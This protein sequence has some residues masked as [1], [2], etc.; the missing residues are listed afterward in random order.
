MVV[1][2][3]QEALKAALEAIPA[4]A[5]ISAAGSHTLTQI[6]YDEWAKGQTAHRDFKAESLAKYG[7][8]ESGELR[9]QGLAADV[10]FSSVTAISTEG[11][12]YAV[13]LTGTRTGGF[14]PAKLLVIGELL[15]KLHKLAEI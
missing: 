11:E 7:T 6:G 12:L 3:R 15:S 14:V 10:F 4:G 2:T 13:D 5:S 8:P 1:N 9:R